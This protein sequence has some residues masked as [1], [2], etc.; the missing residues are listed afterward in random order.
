MALPVAGQAH[1]GETPVPSAS[2]PWD[3]AVLG[4]VVLTA[5][6]TILPGILH[7]GS[8]IPQWQ[9]SLWTA[10]FQVIEAL[11]GQVP[12]RRLPLRFLRNTSP[13]DGFPSLSVKEGCRYLLLLARQGEA[14]DAVSLREGV[15]EIE[16]G[17]ADEARRLLAEARERAGRPATGADR[18]PVMRLVDGLRSDDWEDRERASERLR[19]LGPGA[20]PLLRSLQREERD[21]EVLIRLA[22]VLA[23]LDVQR[24]RGWYL[25]RDQ[26]YPFRLE[27]TPDGGGGA[28]AGRGREPRIDWGPRRLDELTFAIRGLA[29][30]RSGRFRFRKTYDAA[31]GGDE[32]DYEGT[33]LGHA[34]VHGTWGREGRFVM[35]REE[36]GPEAG[37]EASPA[38]RPGGR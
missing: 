30:P 29:E 18:E 14:W 1:A 11:E 25:Q 28:F 2:P 19:A 34:T 26:Q 24:W 21:S 16:S 3:A 22:G 6:E 4:E 20:V 31:S 13:D 23:V 10:T 35:W 12:V 15:R 5:S 17:G 27:L 38:P 36:P 7:R 32:W 37:A 33:L 9:V 8:D